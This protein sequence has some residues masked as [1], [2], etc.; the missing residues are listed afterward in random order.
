M[1]RGIGAQ[2]AKADFPRFQRQ[3]SNL[4]WR[5]LRP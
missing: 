1:R 3:V 2:S 5:N 4:P